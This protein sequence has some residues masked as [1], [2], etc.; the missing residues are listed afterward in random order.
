MLPRRL[1][2][3]L[4]LALALALPWV[5]P[6]V[7]ANELWREKAYLP[8][9]SAIAFG[10]LTAMLAQVWRPTKD[11]ARS[12]FVLSV[13]SAYGAYMVKDMTWTFAVSP[14]TILACVVLGL[15]LARWVSGPSTVWLRS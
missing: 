14:P 15:A 8:G 3:V 10:V 9:M 2:A 1:F 12:L 5:R 13:C 11:D 6:G 7:D 4:L